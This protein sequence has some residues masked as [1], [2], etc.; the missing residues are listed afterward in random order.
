V[1]G[2]HHHSQ[3]S[4]GL[5]QALTR[6]P[7]Y[8]VEGRLRSSQGML[9]SCAGLAGL[10]V[11]GDTCLIGDPAHNQDECDARDASPRS[12]LAEV[13]GV[14]EE[15]VHLLPFDYVR[16]LGAGAPV[17]LVEGLDRVFPSHLWLGR[18]L[19]PLARPLDDGPPLVGGPRGYRLHTQA[20]PAHRRQALGERLDLGVRA[21]NLF[22]PC[23][24][25]QRL[26]I[27]AGAGL[28]KSTLLAMLARNCKADALVVGLVGERGREVRHF[29]DDVV[30]TE[31]RARSVAVVAT[32]DMPPMLRRR[33]AQLTMTVAEALRDE[34]RN[35]LCLLDSVTRYAMAL[36]EIH[37]AAGEPPTSK[38]YPPSVFSEL[39]QLLERAGPGDGRGNIT[40]LFTVLVEG[41]DLSDPIADAVRAILD[42]HIV[43][44]RQIADGGRFPAVDVLRSLSRTAP[45]VYP[46]EERPLVARARQLIR[47]HAEMADLIQLGTY[48]TGSDPSVDEAIRVRP[49]LEAVLAQEI[50]QASSISDDVARLE[51]ALGMHQTARPSR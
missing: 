8:R 28:G 43:L 19:D 48:R 44:D 16:G 42:G 32:S 21:L 6:L 15:L 25:G 30:G 4:G 7:P 24:V 20:L 41:D 12:R 1:D 29:L 40:A 9:M 35:V 49:A 27:F 14:G 3:V 47:A 33:A 51:V 50:D 31:G 39:P 22:T 5:N 23:R 11:I 10:A 45:E 2:D 13:V 34:G 37:L 38:G 18:V 26:G 36:R 46:P 17:R